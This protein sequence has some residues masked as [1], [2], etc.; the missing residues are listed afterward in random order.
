MPAYIVHMNP[1]HTGQTLVNNRNTA[2]VFVD[3][4]VENP[5]VAAREMVK[6]SHGGPAGVWDDAPVTELTEAT[7]ASPIFLT[8]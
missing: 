6:A 5:Q 4:E 8:N 1:G 7:L 3:D 2:P